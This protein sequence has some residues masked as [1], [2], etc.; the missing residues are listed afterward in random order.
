MKKIFEW[1]YFIFVS[2]PVAIIVHLIAS[3]ALMLKIKL[4]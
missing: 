3:I 4:K 2:I 1:V